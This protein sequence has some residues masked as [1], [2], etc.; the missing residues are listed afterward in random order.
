MNFSIEGPDFSTSG[1]PNGST[2]SPNGRQ[3][4]INIKKIHEGQSKDPDGAKHVVQCLQL[5]CCCCCCGCEC[6]EFR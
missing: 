1:N 5:D 2:A 3:E 6:H 4:C